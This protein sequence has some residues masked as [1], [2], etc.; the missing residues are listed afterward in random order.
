MFS[1]Q[2]AS[3]SVVRSP[4]RESIQCA[5]DL[6]TDDVARAQI[7]FAL[8]RFY[9]LDFSMVTISGELSDSYAKK[10]KSVQFSVFNESGDVCTGFTQEGLHC[11][12]RVSIYARQGYA[13]KDALRKNPGDTLGAAWNAANG[14]PEDYPCSVDCLVT[15][16]GALEVTVNPCR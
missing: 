15:A 4:G 6:V 8:H 2:S 3:S 14:Y 10:D 1:L 12:G 5:V 9:E 13:V 11:H 7:L 16:N